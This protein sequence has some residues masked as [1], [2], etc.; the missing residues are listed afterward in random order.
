MGGVRATGLMVKW[1]ARSVDN[2]AVLWKVI[3]VVSGNVEA[4]AGAKEMKFQRK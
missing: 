1:I 2:H 3:E 4:V